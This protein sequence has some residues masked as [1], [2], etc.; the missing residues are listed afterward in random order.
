M[1]LY[2]YIVRENKVQYSATLSK[3]PGTRQKH[4]DNQGYLLTDTFM[5]EPR[6][7]VQIIEVTLCMYCCVA[8]ILQCMWFLVFQ[9]TC[10]QLIAIVSLGGRYACIVQPQLSELEF[11]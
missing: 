1:N 2:Y 4:S 8:V 3:I 6:Q 11:R 5:H 10:S 7:N 9:S